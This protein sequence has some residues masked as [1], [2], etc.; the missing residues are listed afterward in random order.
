ML[1]DASGGLSE[2]QRALQDEDCF[3]RSLQRTVEEVNAGAD[4][5]GDKEGLPRIAR[6]MQPPP[7]ENY[8]PRK[9]RANSAIHSLERRIR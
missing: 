9:K 2:C 3:E 7:A 6:M 8:T 5:W 4:Q 1:D